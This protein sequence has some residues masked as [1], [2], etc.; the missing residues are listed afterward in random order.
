MALKN[1]DGTEFKLTRPNP[2][3][4]EQVFWDKDKLILHNKIGRSIILSDDTQPVKNIPL[5]QEHKEYKKP[6]EPVIVKSLEE[7]EVGEIESDKVQ[8]WCL[9]ASY[10]E[11][12]DAMYGDSYRKIRYGNKFLFEA[13]IQDQGDLHIVFWTNTKAVT[14]GSVLYPRTYDKRWWRVE[15]IHQEESGY[16]VYATISDYQPSFS[17]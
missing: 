16:S 6:D 10:K 8:V 1:R 5:V 2:I 12:K 9:P 7:P 13:I 15:T 4:S 3:M 17:D 11:Y 14:E